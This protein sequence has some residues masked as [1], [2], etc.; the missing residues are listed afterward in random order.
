[1][2]RIGVHEFEQLC[3]TKQIYTKQISAVNKLVQ[4][5][6]NSYK[7]IYLLFSHEVKKYIYN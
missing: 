4:A 2:L 6:P 1:M 5:G 3:L 7:I